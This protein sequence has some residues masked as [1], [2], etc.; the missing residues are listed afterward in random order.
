[1]RSFTAPLVCLVLL[2]CQRE[3]ATEAPVGPVTIAPVPPELPA[4]HQ[5]M[6][7]WFGDH[8]IVLPAEAPS[9]TRP[10]GK[11]ATDQRILGDADNDGDVDYWDLWALWHYLTGF[12]WIAQLQFYSFDLL[13]IDR[14]GDYDWDDLEY[15][16]EY[17]YASLKP[18]NPYGIG[19]PLVVE[20]EFNIELVFLDGHGFTASQMD[21]LEEAAERWEAIITE[22]VEDQDFTRNPFNTSEEDWWTEQEFDTY[23]HIIVDDV[24]DDLRVFVTTG[25]LD[26]SWGSA[27]AFLIRGTSDLPILGAV[28]IAEEI[29]THHYESNGVLL[30]VM[31]HELG[32]TLGFT[33]WV[34]E[35]RYLLWN[36]SRDNPGADTYFSGWRT[37][38]VF[39]LAARGRNY[40]GRRTPV[41]NAGVLNPGEGEMDA[42]SNDSHWRESVFDNELMSSLADGYRAA[43]ISAITIRSFEDV[44]Y[45]VDVTQADPYVIPPV[46]KP[47]V[48][49][50][51]P[52]CLVLPPGAVHEEW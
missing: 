13:D 12:G 23:G 17:L 51:V 43:P 46:A 48:A 20:P 41:E 22:D 31:L 49:S 9:A 11:V 50:R 2:A 39:N 36:P 29:L 16:G 1:M 45:E 19:E 52:F 18:A 4:D 37:R 42:S 5:A 7:A 34:W 33:K 25:D 30:T 40:R 38:L 44:G 28:T 32:H 10:V 15:L 47:V 35:E 3:P 8:G 6:V 24:V 14:D 26:G 21:L 27:G